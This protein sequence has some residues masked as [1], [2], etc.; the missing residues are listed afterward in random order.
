MK[1]QPE[2]PL[3]VETGTDRALDG[4]SGSQGAATSRIPL[5]PIIVVFAWAVGRACV[6]AGAIWATATGG[7]GLGFGTF[8]VMDG[9]WYRHISE[10]GFS[11]TNAVG[12]NG[13]P[14][15][16]GLPAVI[17]FGRLLGIPEAWS[18]V[19][20]ANLALLLALWGLHVA[21]SRVGGPKVGAV[22]VWSL[23]VFPFTAAFSMVYPDVY[24]LAASVWA[25]VAVMD[26]SP[27]TDGRARSHRRDAAAAGLCAV[28]AAMR[29]NG[30]VVALAVAAGIVIAD[31][32]WRRAVVI[33]LPSAAVVVAWL[34]TLWVWTGDPLRF[35]DA[36][37]GWAEQSVY[38][39]LVAGGS[40]QA[41]IDAA[42]AAAALVLVGWQW[43]RLP[44]GWLVF[45]A[46][47]LIPSFLLGVVGFGRY[48]ATCFC[49][50][51]AAGLA[52]QRMPKVLRY[53]LGALSGCTLMWM[54]FLTMHVPD[55][56]WVP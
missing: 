53:G 44:R 40:P 1:D 11:Y 37:Q 29:P 31:R 39:L 10:Y 26:P 23:A 4:A 55:N 18:G 2:G 35:V 16:P 56:L 12:Q 33:A 9:D 14:F 42:V 50:F 32:A 20:L 3:A 17:G 48:V 27:A 41:R 15:F 21:A 36:K 7:G 49:V 45:A 13:Y 54:A 43:R 25:F 52:L 34:V 38:T 6:L 24:V 8:A 30:I 47:Y 46:A 51:V 19:V 28:A 22:A 5:P